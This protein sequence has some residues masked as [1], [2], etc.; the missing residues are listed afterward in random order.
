[1]TKTKFS[2]MIEMLR[3]DTDDEFKFYYNVDNEINGKN[4]KGVTMSCQLFNAHQ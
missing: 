3:Q 1:M 4:K 2:L